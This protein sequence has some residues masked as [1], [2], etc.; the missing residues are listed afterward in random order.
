MSVAVAVSSGG[1]VV[2]CGWLL[3]GF[4]HGFVYDSN[5]DTMRDLG[6]LRGGYS[7]AWAINS[8]GDIV[9]ESDG[10]AFLYRDGVMIDLNALGGALG[11]IGTA[12]AINDRGQIVGQAW[13]PSGCGPH[14]FLRTPIAQ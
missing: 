7:A 14:A 8:A 9:G 12:M 2:G 13:F 10:S 11:N 1:I 6:S 3:G 5:Q 4:P